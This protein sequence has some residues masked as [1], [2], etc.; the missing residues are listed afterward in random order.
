MNTAVKPPDP[1]VA[2]LAGAGYAFGLTW[3]TLPG[4]ADPAPEARQVAA[5]AGVSH[6]VVAKSGQR[7]LVGLAPGKSARGALAAAAIAASMPA[8]R[9]ILIRLSTDRVWLCQIEDS[10]LNPDAD[11]VLDDAR[12]LQMVQSLCTAAS[13]K[14]KPLPIVCSSDLVLDSPWLEGVE[15]APITQILPAAAPARVHK[16]DTMS[17]RARVYIALAVIVPA[18]LGYH[19]FQAYTARQ[20]ASRLA[21]EAAAMERQQTLDLATATALREA[22]IQKA[23]LDALAVDTA[24]PAPTTSITACKHA[25]RAVGRHIGG[26]KVRDVRCEPASGLLLANLSIDHPSSSTFGTP[27]RL[28][29]AATAADATVSIDTTLREA[30]WTQRLTPPALRQSLTAVDQLPTLNEFISS[31]TPLLARSRGQRTFQFVIAPPI[32]RA[33]RVTD[34]TSITADGTPATIDVPAEQTYAE[35]TIRLDADLLDARVTDALSLRNVRAVSLEY[36]PE[37]SASTLHLSYLVRP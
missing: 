31:A 8:R 12:A 18:A 24:S 21:L 26:Y 25:V 5:G 37:R 28:T 11:L 14:S 7:W 23:V 1:H 16:L 9:L 3:R 34:P 33:I 15:R 10:G 29:A 27:A 35:G 30:T 20:E 22:A 19:Q 2:T 17:T 4:L 6:G 13:A 36:I 32:A